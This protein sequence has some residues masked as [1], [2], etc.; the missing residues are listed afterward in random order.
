[1]PRDIVYG[2][3]PES[4]IAALENWTVYAR[5][6]FLSDATAPGGWREA[7]SKIGES[8][9]RGVSNHLIIDVALSVQGVRSMKHSTT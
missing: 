7:P 1:V 2:T 6:V 8:I 4:A 5:L 3:A 9:E